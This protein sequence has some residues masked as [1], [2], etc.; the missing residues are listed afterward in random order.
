MLREDALDLFSLC[1]EPGEEFS[2]NEF[3]HPKKISIKIVEICSRNKE[4]IV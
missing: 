2:F 4:L 1:Y 3:F